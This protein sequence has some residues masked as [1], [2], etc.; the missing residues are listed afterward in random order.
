[1]SEKDLIDL[2]NIFPMIKILINHN[3]DDKLNPI[4][5]LLLN[6][7]SNK[8]VLNNISTIDNKINLE[9]FFTISFHFAEKYTN[10]E[11]FNQYTGEKK[12]IE[13]MIYYLLT[14]EIQ[15]LINELL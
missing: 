6:F 12:M 10:L 5:C 15:D 11:K 14:N 1:M 9:G 3:N 4:A 2:N 7:N 8:S 13:K